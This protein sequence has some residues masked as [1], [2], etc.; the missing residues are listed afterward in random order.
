[1]ARRDAGLFQG[2]TRRATMA[3]VAKRAGVSQ[4][5]VSLVMN[6]VGNTR[7]SAATRAR[8]LQAAE[9]IGYRVGRRVIGSGALRSIVMLL[10]EVSTSPFAATS[11]IG[12]QDSA[13][14]SGCVLTVVTTRNDPMLE[15]A[16]LDLL[17]EQPTAGVIY[18]AIATRRVTPPDRLRT[19][20]TVLL[21]CYAADAHYPSVIPGNVVGARAATEA[22]LRAGHRRIAFI[23]GETWMDAARDRLLGYKQALASW[24]VAADPRLIRSGKWLLNEA[25]KETRA[26]MALHAPPTAIFCASDRMALGCYGALQEMGRRI[27]D[28]VSVAGFD[29]DSIARQLSPALT[30][31]MLPHEEMGRWSVEQ[32]LSYEAGAPGNRRRPVK[33]ECPL[34]ER[35][36]IAPPQL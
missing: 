18:A 25:Y 3:D 9:D 27:P 23:N 4:A 32:L 12:A 28:D 16:A 6:G 14:Q 22:L 35:Q 2:L 19:V 8:V 17:L 30:T 26:L 21:N 36:S 34:V 7:I 13:W 5:T 15:D 29:D 24:D 20:P 10:D 33:L 11:I 31:I 1:M